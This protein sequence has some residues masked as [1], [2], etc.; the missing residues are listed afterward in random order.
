[1]TAREHPSEAQALAL[2]WTKARHR[3]L[4]E[5]KAWDPY[6]EIRYWPATKW[7][8]DLFTREKRDLSG[9]ERTTLRA[10]LRAGLL[11]QGDIGGDAGAYRAELTGAGNHLLIDW[12][13]IHPDLDAGGPDV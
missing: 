2:G 3:M 4:R 1:M 5:V 6:R 11:Q 13:R 8:P 10:L 9:A 12:D 7:D